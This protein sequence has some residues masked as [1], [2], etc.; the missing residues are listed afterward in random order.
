YKTARRAGGASVEAAELWSSLTTD[1]VFRL[2]ASRMIQAHGAHTDRVW[3]YAFIW[4]SELLD[5]VLGSCHALEVPFVWGTIDDPVTA[6]LVGAGD[7]AW[8]LSGLMQEAWLAFARQGDPNG[9]TLPPW[10][11]YE[12]SEQATMILGETCSVRDDPYR[13]QLVAWEGIGARL[14]G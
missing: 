10:P 4:S 8:E 3:S 14:A 2:P 1:W 5:G 7:K 9:G 11:A 13:A 12:A 6:A